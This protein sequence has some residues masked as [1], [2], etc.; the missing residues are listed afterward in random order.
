[1]L[2]L[3]LSTTGLLPKQPSLLSD[4]TTIQDAWNENRH[5]QQFLLE[6]LFRKFRKHLGK[7]SFL[8]LNVWTLIGNL[9]YIDYHIL[10]SLIYHFLPYLLTYL[11]TEV[12]THFLSYSLLPFHHPPF[13]PPS[14]LPFH[15]PPSLPP[16]FSHTIF[17]PL[18]HFL[19]HCNRILNKWGR[20][21]TLINME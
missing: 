5:Q 9:S 7:F 16:F 2:A 21:K 4:V 11:F 10:P 8:Y 12:L 20:I 1:M 6:P 3:I 13:L 17:P 18:H 14:S 15:R 19:H